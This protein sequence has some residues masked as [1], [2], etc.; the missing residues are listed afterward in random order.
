MEEGQYVQE[1]T[2][3]YDVADLSTV[4]IQAQIYEEDLS[5]L[6]TGYEHGAKAPDVP[7]LDVTATT[8]SFPN[9]PFHGKLSF[10]YP[11]VDQDSRTVT[12][13]FELANP[14]HKLRPGGTAEVAI[15]IVPQDVPALAEAISDPHGKAMLEAGKVLAVPESAVIDTG[16]QKI[17][18]RQSE[19]GVYEGVE[20]SL[21]P[22]MTNSDGVVFYPVLH[23]VQEGDLVVTSGS[24]LV[25][26]E[27]RL[28]PAAG[29][30]Y[31]GNSTGSQ[32]TSG[33]NVRPTTP[34]DPQAKI[35]ASLSKLS[36]EDRRLVEVQ[37][38]CPVLNSVLGSMGPPVKIVVDGQP[39][40]L[41][42]NSCT[43]KALASPK[44]T[45]AQV[46][47]LK[48]QKSAPAASGSP[49]GPTNKSPLTSVSPPDDDAD[50]RAN[51]AKLTP[52]DRTL[53]ESQKFCPITDAR[54]GSMV[55]R[56]KSWSRATRFFCVVRI[57]R[58]KPSKIQKPP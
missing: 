20:V 9:Q 16:N 14:D 42:C 51:L 43:G 50:I 55:R 44:E 31:F 57:V 36:A 7:G 28:N 17:V 34:E 13:R 46:Q 41:C 10:I 18:Y 35:K 53:V 58:S 8:R 15:K 5:L 49:T 21:G 1:G 4:W 22:K 27:T 39:V 6:P 2:P 48:D 54:L 38:F 3:L 11:H 32:S 25:D 26:A 12:V 37:K 47:I 24:F 45:L 52:A 19:P 56:S 33:I 40:F 29:S 30:I 23:G